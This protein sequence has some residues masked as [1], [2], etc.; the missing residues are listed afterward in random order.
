[1]F[2]N[3]RHSL[4]ELEGR[5]GPK[6]A[7]CAKRIAYQR[8]IVMKPQNGLTTELEASRLEGYLLCHVRQAQI[9]LED[10]LP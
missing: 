5:A 10:A 6:S 8:Q 7:G 9:F 3:A 1:M 2:G 4:N